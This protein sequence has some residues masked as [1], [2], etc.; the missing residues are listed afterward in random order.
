MNL[1]HRVELDTVDMTKAGDQ[2]V[3]CSGVSQV[4]TTLLIFALL[5]DQPYLQYHR[6]DKEMLGL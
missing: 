4:H 3:A 2:D 1:R 6:S 5:G